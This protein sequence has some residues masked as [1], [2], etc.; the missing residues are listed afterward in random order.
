VAT[1]EGELVNLELPRVSRKQLRYW[2]EVY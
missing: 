2:R 1:S